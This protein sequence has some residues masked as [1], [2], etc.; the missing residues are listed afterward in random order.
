[1]ETQDRKDKSREHGF[2][3]VELLIAIVVAGV[4]AAVAVVAITGVIDKGET[5]AC[6]AS[7]DAAKA[8]SSVFYANSTPSAFPADFHVLTTPKVLYEIPDDVTPQAPAV[9]DVTLVGK[10]W[11]LQMTPGTATDPPV[12]SCT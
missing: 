6:Q 8:A 4:L 3:L 11:T 1:M 12:F 2:T 5:S 9:G 10:G 7:A